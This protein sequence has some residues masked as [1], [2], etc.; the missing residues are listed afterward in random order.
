MVVIVVGVA[1]AVDRPRDRGCPD[2]VEPAAGAAHRGQHGAP[3]G[4]RLPLLAH[5]DLHVLVGAHRRALPDARRTSAATRARCS[6]TSRRSRS[7]KARSSLMMSA[8]VK[9][10]LQALILLTGVLVFCFY[11]F[12]RPPMLFNPQH[13]AAGAG[14][15]RAR[16][17]TR[18]SRSGSRRA[19]DARRHAAL[20]RVG[21]RR[22]GRRGSRA[23]GAATRSRRG[24]PRCAPVR[25]E[26]TTLVQARSRATRR[27]PTSTT[28]SRRSSS[29][30]CRSASSA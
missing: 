25:G 14:E 10:P 17:R 4:A 23:R 11:L 7:R 19:F 24:T 16:R 30:R 26:A 8:Y 22:R 13:E 5:R 18:R 29:R 6:A 9:I 12:A 15:R 20:A 21:G 27:T 28:C 2:D 1:A 3:A